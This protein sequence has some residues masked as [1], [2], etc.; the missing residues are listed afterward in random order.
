MKNKKP[1]LRR[2]ASRK[3]SLLLLAVSTSPLPFPSFFFATYF[4][5]HL[6][7]YY[8][9][10]KKDERLVFLV[11]DFLSTGA[12]LLCVDNL[13]LSLFL[14][15]SLHFPVLPFL[16]LLLT[17][18]VGRWEGR[19]DGLEEKT[20]YILFSLFLPPLLLSFGLPREADAKEIEDAHGSKPAMV[21][22]FNRFRAL[23]LR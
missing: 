11:G 8:T 21:C 3:R 7:L 5:F 22:F 20:D 23:S 9:K 6:C 13:P 1:F 15:L 17:S 12:L 16:F 4:V 19:G 2:L 14:S 18:P 10:T